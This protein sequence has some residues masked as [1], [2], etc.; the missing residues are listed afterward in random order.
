MFPTICT[1]DKV[2]GPQGLPGAGAVWAAT[3]RDTAAAAASAGTHV[4]LAG[5]VGHW[6]VPSGARGTDIGFALVGQVG[7]L[8]ADPTY[9][10]R[11]CGAAATLFGAGGGSQTRFFWIAP[12]A[13]FAAAVAGQK[14][15][16]A[17]LCGDDDDDDVPYPN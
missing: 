14:A 1:F 4:V 16:L 17:A 3:D 10:I 7:I 8:H 11:F 9:R 15:A 12:T 5:V 6:V 2:R 13:D